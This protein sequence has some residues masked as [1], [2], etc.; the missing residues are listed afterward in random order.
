MSTSTATGATAHDDG[1]TAEDLVLAFLDALGAADWDKVASLLAPG[2]RY[3]D[4]AYGS[5]LRGPDAIVQSFKGWRGGF[6]DSHVGEIKR[7]V[8]ADDTAV[9]EV[10]WRG[11]HQGPFRLPDGE[12]IPATGAEVHGPA[13]VVGVAVDG[14]LSEI[15]HYFDNVTVADQLRAAVNAA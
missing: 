12:V 2:V 4:A 9:V 14:K 3:S 8:S 11:T 6:P 5:G 1:R 7:T 10:V 15:A 13:A